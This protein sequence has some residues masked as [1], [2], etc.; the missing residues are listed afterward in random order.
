MLIKELQDILYQYKADNISV[1]HDVKFQG[2][3]YIVASC[4]SNR[5]NKAVAQYII[6]SIKQSYSWYYVEGLS[7]A[8]WI[9]IEIDNVSIHLFVES[10]R[11]YYTVDQLWQQAVPA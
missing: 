7:E 8:N 3:V 5:H 6:D 9:L 11:N 2:D 1:Y 4:T 10:V